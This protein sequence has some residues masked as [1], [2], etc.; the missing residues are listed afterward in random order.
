MK[1][2]AQ[3][4]LG[5]MCASMMLATIALPSSAQNRRDQQRPAPHPNTQ[6]RSE[7]PQPRREQPRREQPRYEQPHQQRGKE[8]RE[9]QQFNR[10]PSPPDMRREPQFQPRPQPL[11]QREYRPYQPPSQGH[12]SGQWLNQHREMPPDQQRRALEND[13]SFRRLPR[14]RQQEY[15]QRLQRFNSMPPDRQQQVLRRME[16]WEHLTP[17]QKQQFQ[18]VRSQF[19]GLPPDRRQAVRNAIESLRAMPPD[20]RQREIQSGRFGQFSPQERQI[21]NG[22]SRLPLAPA[23]G[24]SAPQPDQSGTQQRYIPRPPH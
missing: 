22:A 13:P 1:W 24:E 7:Q 8:S 21:L 16:T 15:E 5:C 9:R 20:A 4:R 14:E 19:N 10:P 11:P 23:P 6:P 12:H 17:Q 18:G 2:G 3:I